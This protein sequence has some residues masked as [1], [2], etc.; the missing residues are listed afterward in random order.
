MARYKGLILDKNRK[1]E[2]VTITLPPDLNARWNA[3][4]KKHLLKKSSMVEELLEMI[5]P[6]LEEDNAQTMIKNA[7]KLNASAMEKL[8]DSL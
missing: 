6:T 4:A 1:K 5:L 2:R 3:V 8:S 7:L